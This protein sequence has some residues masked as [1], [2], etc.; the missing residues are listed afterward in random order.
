MFVF[1]A[2][3]MR[4]INSLVSV[5]KK[6]A[7]LLLTFLEAANGPLLERINELLPLLCQLCKTELLLIMELFFFGTDCFKLNIFSDGSIGGF[8]RG[9]I[10]FIS[11]TSEGRLFISS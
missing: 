1:L 4:A 3:R 8:S 5:F 6:E 10:M 9:L 2:V 11:L 7:V